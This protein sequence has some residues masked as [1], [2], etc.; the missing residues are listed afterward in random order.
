MKKKQV[1]V[2]VQ[3]SEAH[4]PDTYVVDRNNLGPFIK[5]Y[6]KR[7]VAA[8]GLR[9]VELDDVDD[10]SIKQAARECLRF[11]W[12]NRFDMEIVFTSHD[13]NTFKAGGDFWLSRNGKKGFK[14]RG[15]DEVFLR[16]HKSAKQ[17]GPVLV[18]A[19]GGKITMRRRPNEKIRGV[20]L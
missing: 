10:P 15:S 14:Q 19:D 2:L 18:Q 1:P 12:D 11:Y 9:G 6:L 20:L 3:V 13:Y 8:S 16:L 5:G 17:F 7:A 4:M